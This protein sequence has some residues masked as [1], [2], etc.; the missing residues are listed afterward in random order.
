MYAHGQG[1]WRCPLC[2]L[3]AWTSTFAEQVANVDWLN[4][5]PTHVEVT[6]S[7]FLSAILATTRKEA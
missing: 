6:G 5:G 2:V 1:I 3:S 7:H 4:A